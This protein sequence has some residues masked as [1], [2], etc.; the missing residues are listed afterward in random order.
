MRQWID[1]FLTEKVFDRLGSVNEWNL[2]R[3]PSLPEYRM[4]AQSLVPDLDLPDDQGL[5][6]CL[7]QTASQD[8]YLWDGYHAPHGAIQDR[9]TL[10]PC[11]YLI[12]LPHDNKVTILTQ[13]RYN[14]L[15]LDTEAVNA[16]VKDSEH[17][18]RILRKG[19]ELIHNS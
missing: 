2:F 12:I 14:R 6:R 16:M 8:L 17:L 10:G 5:I 7:L 18:N 9:Y 11:I 1:L 3:N 13:W 15:G 19:F 4:V